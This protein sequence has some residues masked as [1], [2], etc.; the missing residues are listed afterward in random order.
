MVM[1][2]KCSTQIK[3]ETNGKLIDVVSSFKY[4]GTCSSQDGDLKVLKT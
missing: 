4:L 1:E 3:I 2:E